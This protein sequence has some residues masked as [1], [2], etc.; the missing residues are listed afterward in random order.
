MNVLLQSISRLVKRQ[1]EI[2]NFFRAQG[3]RRKNL[4]LDLMEGSLL[5]QRISIFAPGRTSRSNRPDG[6]ESAPVSPREGDL[7]SVFRS[8]L[9]TFFP[10]LKQD[11]LGFDRPAIRDFP[12]RILRPRGG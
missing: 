8:S 1:I 6:L 11:Y 9:I 3:V 10:C 12:G 5:K 4:R 2:L 7:Y